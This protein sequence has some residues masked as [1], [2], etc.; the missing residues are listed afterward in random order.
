MIG[1]P[2]RAF[3]PLLVIA[4][5]LSSPVF[6][7]ALLAADDL[8]APAS[9]QAPQA[10]V[11]AKTVQQANPV[12]SNLPAVAPVQPE[13]AAAAEV[14]VQVEGDLKGQMKPVASDVSRKTPTDVE[15]VFNFSGADWREVMQWIADEAGLSLQADSYPKGTVNY[16]DNSRTYRLGDA[17]DVI[18]GLLLDRGFSLV[19]RGRQL[20]LI[21]QESDTAPG[22]ISALAELVT[23]DELD[24]RANSD[25]VR[26]VFALGSLSA[27]AAKVEIGQLIG[28]A[29]KVIVLESAKQVVVTETVGRLK[30]IR[31]LLVNASAA[32][33]DVTEIVLKYRVADELLEIARPLIGLESGANSSDKIR[34]ATGLYGDRLYATGDAATRALLERIIERADTPLQMNNAET[35][36]AQSLPKLETYIV[37][38]VA[39]STVIDVLQTLLAGL[40]DTRLTIDPQAGGIIAYARPETH[41]MIQQTIDKLEGRGSTF[42]IIQL[43]RLEPSQALATIN[44]FFGV[45]DGSKK[46]APT[47]DGDPATGRLWVRGT[48]EQIEMVRNLIEKL[49]GADSLGEMGDRIRVLPYTGRTAQETVEQL[50]NLWQVMGK[51]NKI[52]MVTPSSGGGSAAINTFPQRRV[53]GLNVNDNRKESSDVRPETDGN[54]EAELRDKASLQDDSAAL[55]D[56]SELTLVSDTKEPAEAISQTVDQAVNQA[57][58][59]EK[60]APLLAAPDESESEKKP[61]GSGDIVITMTPGGMVIASDDPLALSDFEQMM[62]TLSDQTALATAEPTVFWL[63]YTK[64]PEAADLITKILGGDSGSS[65]GGGGGGLA[66]SIMGELGGGMLGGLLGI[67]GGGGGDSATSSILTTTGSVSIVADGRLNALIVQANSVDMQT[68][69]MILEVIDREESPEDVRT[70]SKPQLIPVIY[71]NAT[72]VA[73]IVKS[74]YAERSGEQGGGR[75]GQPQVSPQD[76]IN[77]IRGGGGGRGGRGGGNEQAT[78]PAPVIIAV[79]ARSNSLIVTAPPQD[80]DDIRELVEAIDAGGMQSE[81]TV[82]IVSLKGT[83]KAEVVQQALDSILGTKAKTSSSSAAS[84]SGATAAAAGGDNPSTED[85]QR[86]IDFFRQIRERGGLGGA[87]GGGAPGGGGPPTGFGGGTRGGTSGGGDSG[88]TRGR[89]GR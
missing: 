41:V 14:V 57:Q 85:I 60:S 68:I 70:T 32:S 34:I 38:T 55:P 22:L 37:S 69:E 78:K 65:G 45:T 88:R 59:T 44:K 15:L 74:V 39:P 52:R 13:V 81:E 64:A 26:C 18:N 61:D 2:V 11:D 51:K 21:D 72:D 43:R 76:L 53:G 40:P 77:A 19:R 71:Q 84:P 16:V 50:Q 5:L 10:E 63:K 82:E 80:V 6:V 36:E 4:A 46:D 66:G 12:E 49:E 83:V 27:E 9:E 86:R 75:G 67:G 3:S 30:A 7:S 56:P 20:I 1:L 29:G 17:M 24:T 62:R 48:S 28:P 47:I 79:D 35:G 23:S 42:E 54:K 8:L 33:S 25:I 89:G 58:S 31:A 73:N 87:P